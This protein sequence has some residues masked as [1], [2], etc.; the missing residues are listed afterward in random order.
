MLRPV[1]NGICST[2]VDATDEDL[3]RAQAI[4]SALPMI[5]SGDCGGMASEVSASDAETLSKASRRCLR[6]G[7]VAAPPGAQ[8]GVPAHDTGPASESTH[9]LSF[10][11][12]SREVF[13][14]RTHWLR[15]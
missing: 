5:R 6:N 2:S 7:P 14:A 13:C 9:H 1:T 4:T 11:N 10:A 8:V 3:A 15:L 12:N